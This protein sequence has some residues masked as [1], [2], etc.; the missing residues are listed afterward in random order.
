M[1][2][3]SVDS[4]SR[5]KAFAEKLGIK[6]PILRDE[7]KTVSRR[8]GVLMPLIRLARRTTFIIDKEGVIQ[9]IEQGGV[10]ADPASAQQACSVIGHRSDK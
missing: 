8:Y 3:I 7:R 4:R 2:G 9:Q 6:F 5:N 10:A 1:I